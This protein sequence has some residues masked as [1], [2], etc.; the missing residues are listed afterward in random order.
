MWPRHGRAGGEDSLPQTS[1]HALFNVPPRYHC[2]SWPKG[3]T[4]TIHCTTIGH[5]DMHHRVLKELA[6]VVAMMF[7]IVFEKSWLLGKIAGD[8]K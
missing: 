1:G 8:W 6:D 5:N 7:S 2:S 4:A 3:H